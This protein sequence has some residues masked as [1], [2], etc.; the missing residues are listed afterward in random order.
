VLPHV[1]CIVDAQ[2]I[3]QNTIEL[4]KEHVSDYLSKNLGP[5]FLP[6]NIKSRPIPD[7]KKLFDR[8]GYL[9]KPMKLLKAYERAW[10]AAS[11]HN[12]AG[13][14]QL[15][16]DLTD[17]IKGHG[18]ITR[19]RPKMKAKGTLDPK[20]RRFIGVPQKEH[21]SREHQE[22][23]AHLKK[24]PTEFIP[25]MQDDEEAV[26]SSC[27]GNSQSHTPNPPML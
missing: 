26:M 3:T 18:E 25:D 14:W 19:R 13:A 17:L 5:D 2:E 21:K 16:S 6:P 27:C 11:F 9:L 1:H 7:Q 12:R 8:V 24:A 20:S 4:L 15:N 22:L 23:I 10:V